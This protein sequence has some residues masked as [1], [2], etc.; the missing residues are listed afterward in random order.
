M[1]S[2]NSRWPGWGWAVPEAAW[3]VFFPLQE[4]QERGNR[5]LQL[6]RE[7]QR[8]RQSNEDHEAQV[9]AL[10]TRLKLRHEERHKLAAQAHDL[11]RL[12][13]QVEGERDAAQVRGE[14]RGLLAADLGAVCVR[15]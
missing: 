3:R 5:V 14:A 8:L 4:S 11:E 1:R 7:V 15:L 6:E 2:R 9:I 10:E 12:V 13:A